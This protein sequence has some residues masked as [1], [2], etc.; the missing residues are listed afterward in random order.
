MVTMLALLRKPRSR[1]DV[2]VSRSHDF[3][4]VKVSFSY[5]FVRRFMVI[6][7]SGSEIKII[8]SRCYNQSRC[9]NYKHTTRRWSR[10][11]VARLSESIMSKKMMIVAGKL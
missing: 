8:E 1:S 3:F 10:C 2:V 4:G 9:Y 7:S 6:R 5:I 11:E